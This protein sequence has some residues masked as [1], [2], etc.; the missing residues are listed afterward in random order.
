MH[1]FSKIV[2]SICFIIIIISIERIVLSRKTNFSYRV[3][4]SVINR[5]VMRLNNSFINGC[6][7]FLIF[8]FLATEQRGYFFS[9]EL[10]FVFLLIRVDASI[11]VCFSQSIIKRFAT[12][13]LSSFQ[14]DSYQRT[15]VLQVKWNLLII[16]LITLQTRFLYFILPIFCRKVTRRG[17]L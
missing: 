13:A 8:Q 2:A 4:L 15:F 1:T 3:S 9:L 16:F 5:I 11:Q 14:F 17:T 6:S 10:R 7:I 12:Y